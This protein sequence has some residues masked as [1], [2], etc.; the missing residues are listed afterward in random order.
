M[1]QY[2]MSCLMYDS[3]IL[4]ILQEI[5]IKAGGGSICQ[6]ISLLNTLLL[7]PLIFNTAP[8]HWEI[9]HC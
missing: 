8:T 5:T 2:D 4:G 9:N 3:V 1:P 7:A 6:I